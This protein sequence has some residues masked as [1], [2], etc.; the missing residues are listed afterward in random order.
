[1]R[2]G[3]VSRPR[4]ASR[5]RSPHVIVTL[6]VS[7]I[8]PLRRGREGLRMRQSKVVAITAGV[9]AASLLLA[10][11]SSS[12]KNTGG[13]AANNSAE[14]KAYS[15]YQGHSGKVTIYASITDPEAGFLKAA[16]KQFETCTGIT[17]QYTGDKDF[18]TQLKVKVQG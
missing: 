4:Q 18:E 12:K 1:M 8:S 15:D 6:T 16:W 7:G 9:A 11:C 14:C 10:A 13:G 17:I 5:E 3:S 2:N